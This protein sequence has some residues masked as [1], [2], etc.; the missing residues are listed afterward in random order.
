MRIDVGIRRLVKLVAASVQAEILTINPSKGRCQFVTENRRPRCHRHLENSFE[1]ASTWRMRQHVTYVALRE[2]TV[3][4][5]LSVKRDA[6]LAIHAV[7]PTRHNR[8]KHVR[9]RAGA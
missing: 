6:D 9:S 1:E 8:E 2:P 3:F 7:Q 5:V 4:G